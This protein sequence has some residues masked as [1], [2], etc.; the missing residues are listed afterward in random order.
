M[1]DNEAI[2]L[3]LFRA[4][5]HGILLKGAETI[6]GLNTALMEVMNGTRYYSNE[7]QLLLA[8]NSH[9]FSLPSRL[10][11][12][13][14]E[15]EVLRLTSGG[16]SSKEISLAMDI[17]IGSVENY[18]KELLRKTKTKNAAELISFSMLNGVL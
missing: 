11:F 3:D 10:N 6:D 9:Q 5:V 16:K 8:I 15:L 4:G 2:I 13:P 12:T 1:F 14:R 18:R 7:I 17:S